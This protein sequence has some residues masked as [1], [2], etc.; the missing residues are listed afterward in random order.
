[1]EGEMKIKQNCMR[2]A[3]VMI[4]A[5]LTGCAS[6]MGV[7][8]KDYNGINVMYME[9][10]ANGVTYDGYIY[11]FKRFQGSAKFRGMNIIVRIMENPEHPKFVMGLVGYVGKP[12]S[13][14][15]VIDGVK[16]EMSLLN[17]TRT[18]YKSYQ[19]TGGQMKA[20]YDTDE[21]AAYLLTDSIRGSIQNAKKLSI[22]I[23]GIK[24]EIH[25]EDLQNLKA[26][27]R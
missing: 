26:I 9:E 18:T 5:T 2:I 22:E 11:L 24:T 14:S 10:K 13:M 19:N 7:Q 15:L 27:L 3:L 25:E 4:A 12:D 16:S 21:S 20:V 8:Y 6:L 23:N 1:M 17:F